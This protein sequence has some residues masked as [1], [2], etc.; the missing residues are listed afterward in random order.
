MDNLLQQSADNGA[1]AVC[2][3]TTRGTDDAA[4]LKALDLQSDKVALLE[5]LNKVKS[6]LAE[7]T[8]QLEIIKVE[9]GPVYVSGLRSQ[10]E[11]ARV[12]SDQRIASLEAE[13]EERKKK[14]DL[15]IASLEAELEEG[16]KKS[17]IGRAH[18]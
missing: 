2:F 12:Q 18:V 16:K 9:S 13:L 11:E 3:Y 10:L 8:S 1:D 6:A 5:E 4:Q 14:S 7:K 17:E 15:R